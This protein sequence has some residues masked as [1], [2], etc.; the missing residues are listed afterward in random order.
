M[1]FY[2]IKGPSQ[3]LEFRGHPLMHQH[4]TVATTLVEQESCG[5]PTIVCSVHLAC[6]SPWA[7]PGQEQKPAGI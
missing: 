7:S 6:G 3:A 1:H 5:I 4:K 2:G